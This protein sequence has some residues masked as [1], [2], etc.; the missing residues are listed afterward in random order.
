MKF[1]MPNIFG[2]TPAT[3]GAAVN[4]G[5]NPAAVNPAAHNPALELSTKADAGT[6]ANGVVP[7]N[8]PAVQEK[9][10]LD[11]FADLWETPSAD[12]NAATTGQPL[13][14]IDPAKIQEAVRSQNF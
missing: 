6:A 7:A 2:S 3:S 13:F 11:K 12:P 9:S 8:N 1:S 4:P 14:N 5:V 10:G